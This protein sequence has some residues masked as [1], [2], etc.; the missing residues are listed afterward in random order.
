MSVLK[1]KLSKRSPDYSIGK[2]KQICFEIQSEMITI[3]DL[4]SWS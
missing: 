1:K 2:Y 4:L 3:F